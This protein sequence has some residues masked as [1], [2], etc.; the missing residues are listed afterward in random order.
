MCPNNTDV[1][2]ISTSKPR[3]SRSIQKV[4]RLEH[5]FQCSLKAVFCRKDESTVITIET[6]VML[7]TFA[8]QTGHHRN[9]GFKR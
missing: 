8:V 2:C 4:H 6:V 9:Q 3:K 1:M 5:V 7:S